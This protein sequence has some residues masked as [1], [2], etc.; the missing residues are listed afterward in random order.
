M[1]YRTERHRPAEVIISELIT[2]KDT[3]Y[4]KEIGFVMNKLQFITIKLPH[5]LLL[6]RL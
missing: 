1:K 2:T 6:A 4:M 3:G 5:A